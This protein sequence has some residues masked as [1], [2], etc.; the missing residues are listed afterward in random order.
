MDRRIIDY[1][2]RLAPSYDADRFGNSY[3]RFLDAQERALLARLL[4]AGADRV[5]D[6]GCGTGRL[7]DRASHA[8]DASVESLRAAAAR[9]ASGRFCAADIAALPFR[10]ESFDA[11]FSFH[12]FMHLDRA[13]IQAAFAEVARVLRP[14]GVF[15]AD[16]AS[17]LRRRLL[18]RA[19]SGWHGGTSLTREEFAAI[20]ADVGLRM[21][22]CVG[23][24]LA[25][26]HRLPRALRA[27]I[28]AMDRHLAALAPD[29]ASYIVGRFVR[30]ARR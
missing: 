22:D 3:G 26:I 24:M 7:S 29:L 20:G 4:P 6:L 12:V 18:R 30:D 10:A 5:L 25:P 17:A 13:A 19:T 1:Y 8:C 21:T 9:H 2:D 27:P 14:G 15:I 23:I 16:V 11:A 28:V